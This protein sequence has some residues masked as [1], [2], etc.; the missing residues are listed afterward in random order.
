MRRWQ[1]GRKRNVKERCRP[2]GLGLARP[3]LAAAAIVEWPLRIMM[4]DCGPAY[5]HGTARDL[6]GELV[7]ERDDEMTKGV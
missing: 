7:A 4:L 1:A 2:C 3:S 6:G 5:P